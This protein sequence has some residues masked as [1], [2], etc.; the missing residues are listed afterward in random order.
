MTRPEPGR[1]LPTAA[2]VLLGALLAG[3]ALYLVPALA[4]NGSRFA[5]TL[6]A[7]LWGGGAVAL[8]VL[9]RRDMKAADS[10]V[11]A[12]RGAHSLYRALID[13]G[14]EAYLVLDAR[15]AVAFASANVETIL[16]A[17]PYQLQE[18]G[19][20]IDL[21][22]TGDR[23]RVLRAW[24][25][26]RRRP[27]ASDSFE[28]GAW[29]TDGSDC[30]VHVRVMDLGEAYR[31]GTVLFTLRDITPRKTFE[32]EIQH[33][34]YYDP[35]TGLSNRRFFFEQGTKALALARR[36]RGQ[37]AVF[38]LDLDRFKQVNDVLGHEHGDA[39]LEDVAA[40]LRRTLR[41]TDVVA[42]LGGDEFAV[43]LTEVRDENAAGRVAHR[44]L[45]DLP[46]RAGV[47]GHEVAVGASIGVAM[48]PED[49][50]NLESLLKAADLAMYRAK[51][52]DLGVQF[53]RPEL[54]T[55]LTEQMRLEQD[56]RQGLE[57][58]EF[59][60][61]YQPVFHL[62]TGQMVGAEALS[63]W[64]HF[65]RGM[66]VASEFIRLAERSGLIRSL[67]RWAIARAVHQRKTQLGGKWVGWVAVNLSPQSVTDPGLP[68][69][70][71]TVLEGAR[72]EPGS[73]VIEMPERAVLDNPTA[74]ADLMWEI[75]NAGAAIALD[76][77][78]VGSTSFAVL[79]QLPIDI[80]KLHTDFVAGIGEDEGDEHLVEATISIAH[81]IR[82][83]VLAK[84]IERE[85]QVDWLRDTGCDF[86]Q[87]YLVGGPVPAE[88]LGNE[89]AEPGRTPERRVSGEA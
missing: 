26:V 19:G 3:T 32:S 83:K 47:D 7:I 44:L 13:H 71:R 86:V 73:L 81:G 85:H 80:L 10:D 57:Q 33:L 40:A 31:S 70:L 2:L 4:L 20:L 69:Y 56:L 59:H 11:E 89:L 49:A 18:N 79:K 27:G 36:H 77:F 63:R 30:H 1:K 67:D 14:A 15:G 24:S 60:L 9:Y 50:E 21:V 8:W 29:R 46:A 55:I 65:S 82:A 68:E 35:L 37:A 74:A 84:G 75:K 23:R 53:Y 16:G 45:R 61:H 66:V 64:R 39:L 12:A 52:D 43:I 54:R 51:T 88:E 62:A 34:A 41:D 28:I 58:H 72:L 48:Y 22:A 6:A 25:R 17:D 42:R 87:G 76:D 5:A 78:G 38:Y